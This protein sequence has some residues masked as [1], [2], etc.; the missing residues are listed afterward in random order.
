MGI[1]SKF[2]KELK[3]MLANSETEDVVAKKYSDVADRSVACGKYRAWE[4]YVHNM[5][6]SVK[7]VIGAFMLS[8]CN[9][10]KQSEGYETISCIGDTADV[11]A[12]LEALSEFAGYEEIVRGVKHKGDNFSPVIFTMAENLNDVIPEV[13][14]DF[15]TFS[16]EEVQSACSHMYTNTD[17]FKSNAPVKK[18]AFF[19]LLKMHCN[20]REGV[21]MSDIE[22]VES[23]FKDEGILDADDYLFG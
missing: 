6:R 16:L 5:D 9:Y 12:K 4:N 7:Q 21:K 14:I 15:N 23:V 22:V 18:L 20:L 11:K 19:I 8:V 10:F 3:G 13:I 1:D 17:N 2:V